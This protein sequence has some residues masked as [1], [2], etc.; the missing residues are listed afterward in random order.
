MPFQQGNNLAT[1]GAREGAGRKPHYLRARLDRLLREK[2]D[3]ATLGDILDVVISRARSGNDWAVEF[4]FDRIFGKPG[5]ETDRAIVSLVERITENGEADDA[6]S[7]DRSGDG[8]TDTHRRTDDIS[9][10]C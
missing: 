2:A 3:D 6:D 7:V 8:Q 9:G 1:G 5:S 4:V 10:G